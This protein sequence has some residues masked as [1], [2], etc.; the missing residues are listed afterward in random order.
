MRALQ[1]RAT[2]RVHGPYGGRGPMLSYGF[3][4]PGGP[5]APAHHLFPVHLNDGSGLR[6]TRGTHAVRPADGPSCYGS[7]PCGLRATDD[8]TTDA[9]AERQSA[10]TFFPGR[11]CVRPGRDGQLMLI[12]L[13]KSSGFA[14][15]DQ[16][17]VEA[18]R[19]AAPFSRIPD[20]VEHV[21]MTTKGTFEYVVGPARQ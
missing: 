17:A 20:A 4:R 6:D 16:N 15:L 21:F 11:A 8:E 3:A 13:E 9:R 10:S 7:G 1:A 19:C 18:V 2:V 5:R 14:L 12:R